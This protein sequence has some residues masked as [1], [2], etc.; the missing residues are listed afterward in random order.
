M[1]GAEAAEPAPPASVSAAGLSRWALWFGGGAFFACYLGQ[2]SLG[3][4]Q[5][6]II[7]DLGLTPSEGQWVVNSFFLAMAIFAAPGGRLGD[8][9]G[10]RQVLLIALA[11]FAAGSLSA[12]VSQGFV[13]LVVSIG[14]AGMGASTLYPSSAALIANRV[15]QEH[16]GDALGKY[17]AIGATVLVIGPVLAGLMTEAFSWRAMFA[18]QMAIALGL[19]ALGFLRVDNRPAAP[20]ER[21]DATGFC[22]L[23]VGLVALLVSLMQ[24]LTW[25]WDSPPTI[26][27][28]AVGL[29]VLAAFAALELRRDHP[30]LDVSL[31]G[32]RTMRGIVLA[33]FAAQFTINGYFIYIATYLQHVLG[34][35]ALLA[36]VA[37]VPA[38]LLAPLFNIITGRVTDRI[39]PRTP[40]IIGF[41]G[42]AIAYAWIALNVDQDSY[43]A[44]LPSFLLLSVTSAPMFTSLLTGLANAV[45]ASERGD[46]NALVLTVRW[47]GAATG[48]AVLGVVVQNGVSAGQ[49]PGASAYASAFWIEAA[50]VALGALACVVLLRERGG[51]R[52]LAHHLTRPHF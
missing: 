34:Y 17:S 35:G 26:A 45:S 6:S 16:R 27:L 13:W 48:T 11:I 29:A 23:A 25:G 37:M 24:A 38:M 12:T 52:R 44:L 47:I 21:F 10:H 46:A 43:L 40:A 41:G 18:L 28:F 1:A 19:A 8:F 9:Y 31:L 2:V 4:I 49:L 14:I 39:G 32:R 7:S 15:P 51:E 30:L 5:P 22:V 42:A 36:A 3:V 20:P 50:V 33:M